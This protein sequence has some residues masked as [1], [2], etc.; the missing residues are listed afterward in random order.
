[1]TAAES[2]IRLKG[3]FTASLTLLD[4]DLAPDAAACL[5]HCRWL[6]ANGCD[7]IGLLGTT[8]E[9]PSFSAAERRGLL[10]AL[11]EGGI[12]P[13]RLIV[14]TGAAAFSDSAELTA[15]AVD[16]GAAGCLVVPPFYFKNVTDEGLFASYARLIERVGRDSLRLYLY[17][18]P[19]M[20]AVPIPHEV[21]DRLIRSFPGVIAGIKDS[22]GDFANMLALIE[23]FPMLDVFAG[24]ERFLLPVLEAGGAGCIT[25]GGN[26]TCPTVGA[27]YRKWRRD[28]G[29]AETEALQKRVVELRDLLEGAPM[30]PAMKVL[31]A[32]RHDDPGWERVAPPLSALAAE[33]RA[34]FLA[35][36]DRAGLTLP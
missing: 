14:G 27:L 22:S 9:A 29:G 32:H 23:S 4:S 35:R 3:V 19:Q 31:L 36:V 7:G 33:E 12:P 18:F 6:L 15:H 1:M 28:G 26:V 8:G 34:A 25:A 2:D 10:D 16:S 13:E 24:T 11:L 20:S 5:G 21:I 17:H 30:I